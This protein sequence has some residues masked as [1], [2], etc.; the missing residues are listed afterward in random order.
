[1]KLFVQLAVAFVFCLS[2][3]IAA[4]Q[5][6]VVVIPLNSAKKLK[7][8][9]TVSAKGGDFTDPVAAVNSI[10]D[11]TETNPYL[12]LIGPGI[13]T[14]TQTLVMKPYVNIAGSGQEAT[15]LT[16]SISSSTVAASAMVA[17]ANN[18]ALSDLTVE[19]KG[20]SAASIGLYN[21]NSSPVIHNVTFH[22]T[23]GV[24]N[25]GVMNINSS[26]PTMR[27]VGVEATGG[28]ECYGVSNNSGSVPFMT[29]VIV[30]ATA[31]TENYGLR[32][33]GTSGASILHSILMAVGGISYAI[34]VDDA[35]GNVRVL[36]STIMGNTS[37]AGILVCLQSDD[38]YASELN[39]TC[40]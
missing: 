27:D 10:A 20:G 25:V 30:T 4:A 3:S 18:A 33:A 31:G 22:V 36:H 8:V 32:S 9:V 15:K 2:M 11:A 6:K 40:Q 34:K 21:D 19:N 14:L 24:G 1:M 26:K 37:S 23:G 7:N 35:G 5:E 12:L 28:N 13:Y 29:G 38:G 17:G 16:G 39:L